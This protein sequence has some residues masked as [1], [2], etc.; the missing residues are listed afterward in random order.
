MNNQSQSVNNDQEPLYEQRQWL[1]VTLSSIGDAVIT[2]DAEG[3][4][5][6][7]N[8]V[9]QALTGWTQEEAAGVPLN[10]VFKIV[11]EKTRATFENPATRALREGLIV[12]LA[13]HTVL[14]GK[15]GT[16]RAIDDSAA[17]IR[18]AGGEVAGVVLV[19][20]DVTQRRQ[21]EQA[22]RESEERFRLL[23]EAAQ[24]HAIFMLDPQGNIAT[25]NTGAER[26]KGYRAEE[27]IGKHFSIFYPTEAIEVNWP[28]RE[29]EM[30]AAEGRFED[31]GWRLRKDGSKFWANVIITALRD[32]NGNLKGFSKI[33]RDLTE[34]MLKESQ[35]RES[36]NRFRRLFETAKDGIFILDFS[37]GKIKEANP[38]VT[39]LLGYSAQE[40]SGKE[41]WQ[42][43]LFKDIESSQNAFRELQAEGYVRYSDLP[44][45]T[46][47]GRMVEVEFISNVYN[48][49]HHRV[50]Q[51]NIRDITERRQ[52][53]RARAQAEASADLHRRKD[54]FL[55]MLSHELRNPLAAIV[56]AV[57]ILNIQK[58]EDPIQEKAKNIISRQVGHLVVLVNELLEVS[59]ILSGGIQLHQEDIDARGIVQQAIETVLPLIDE[60][61]H[62]LSVSI[63]AEPIWLHADPIRLE[64]V[65]VNLLNNAAKYTSEGGGIW[66][67]LRQEKDEAVLSV[68]DTGVGIDP[69]LLPHIFDLFTQAQRSLDRSQAGL[70]VGLTVVRKLV[71]MQRGTVEAHSKG[72]GHGSE[73]VVRLPLLQSA[74]QQPESVTRERAKPSGQ[75]GRV[76]VVDDNTDAADSIAILLEA[77]GHEVHVSYSA[78]DALEAAVKYQP[79]I[80]LLDIGLPEMD[81]Y[82]VA[83]R[84]RK[85]AEL[86]GMKLI[87]LTGYGQDADRQ[88]SQEAGFDYH[89]V[90]PVD[91]DALTELLERLLRGDINNGPAD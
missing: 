10:E 33:T 16:E 63:A 75:S 34:R 27:I 66:L 85:L 54:E 7:L 53:E 32:E 55:A 11:N 1:Q 9:A 71:E 80:V 50:I 81:G 83:E 76:L 67:S 89:L 73:F 5:T 78:H 14:I 49:N 8:P 84:L 26:I 36:E 3:R 39:E 88:R 4:V 21:A 57:H 15:D 69:E 35:L 61:K 41:L 62:E 70:G 25:W 20:R 51:C 86:K 52:L 65:I 68:R 2:T 91:Y 24:D 46:K 29:L 58:Q 42:I 18:N 30:A 79:D 40:L 44:L 64:E 74:R 90:K 56:N 23:V 6:F 72:L 77:A 12:G 28:K 17:P 87:A 47:D 45:Q 60:R 37:T 13:N 59:R 82:E 19:F 48:V 43:G 22:L 31:E 38:F